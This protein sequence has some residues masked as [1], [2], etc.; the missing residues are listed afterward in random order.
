MRNEYTKI[1]HF[2]FQELSPQQWWVKSDEL[3]NLIKNRYG[4]LHKRAIAGELSSWRNTALGRL[5][6]II[7]LDQFSRNIYR[8][9]KE[10]FAQDAMALALTQE[11]LNLKLDKTI[12][13][14]MRAFCYMPLMHSESAIIHIEA[15]RVFEEFGQNVDF[16][17]KHKNIIDKFGRFPHRNNILKRQ[18]TL[19]EITFLKGPNSSF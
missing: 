12:P 7:V 19:E 13:S 10:S 3:D 15:L 11:M 9:K 4:D 2:W 14:D 18:S 16:E 17:K 8:G 1:I 5:A 6:E